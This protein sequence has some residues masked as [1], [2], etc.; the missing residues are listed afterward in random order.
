MERN[1]L[2]RIISFKVCDLS[3]N[4]IVKGTLHNLIK[5]QYTCTKPKHVPK[6]LKKQNLIWNNL[7]NSIKEM[8]ALVYNLK[9]KY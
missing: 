4:L 1:G 8:R 3:N 2:R 5:S 9:L 7:L 6:T